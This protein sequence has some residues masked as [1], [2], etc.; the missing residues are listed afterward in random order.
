MIIEDSFD[1]FVTAQAP[2]YAQVCQELAAGRKQSHWM[3]FIFPQLRELGR[4]AT[5][6]HFG[7]ASLGEAQAYSA[8]PLLG[9]R[10]QECT[11][12]M[13]CWPD[14]ALLSILPP[15][16]DL[17]FCSSMT[18]FARADPGNPVFRQALAMHCGGDEDPR[19]LRLLADG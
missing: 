12:L 5:A 10:L 6:R 1:H 11:R 7:L 19:T 14:R 9:S 3:W 2:V 16:D 8:H 17:K 4:S 13:L 15:P 18:L